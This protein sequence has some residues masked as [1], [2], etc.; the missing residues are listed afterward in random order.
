MYRFCSG[1]VL[2]LTNR[3]S[4]SSL[5]RIY[6]IKTKKMARIYKKGSNGLKKENLY[7]S[8][9][10]LT[11][12][13]RHRLRVHRAVCCM[14]CKGYEPG[15]HVDHGDRDIYNNVAT[16]LEWVTNAEN[17]RRKEELMET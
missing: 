17:M 13:A 11:R 4:V 8:F 15:L 10:C 12:D 2:D 3:F 9:E 6:N 7:D 14:F 1:K 16:N 5:G